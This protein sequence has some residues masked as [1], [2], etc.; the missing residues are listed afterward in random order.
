M[1]H[2]AGATESSYDDQ[3]VY[4]G[5]DSPGVELTIQRRLTGYAWN[6]D[7]IPIKIA[8]LV[9]FLY[10]IYTLVF[11]LY[12]FITGRSSMAWRSVSGLVALAIGSAPTKALEYTGAGIERTDTF[13]KF[14]SIRE[15]EKDERLELVF[16]QDEEKKGPYRRV[17]IGRA[18]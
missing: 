16:E 9:L 18:Y 11:S 12:T 6:L 5:Q 7:G 10:C 1:S 3:S 2:A 14:V 8:L 17:V 15:A 13:R 4:G